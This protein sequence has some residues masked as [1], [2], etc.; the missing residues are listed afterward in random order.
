MLEFQFPFLVCV[1]EGLSK[2]KSLPRLAGDRNRIRFENT[3]R[4]DSC[5][6]LLFMLTSAYRFEPE[7]AMSTSL[8]VNL[9][10]ALLAM[11]HG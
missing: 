4:Q 11:S 8:I 5:F 9:S 1:E 3:L 2:S 10:C 6:V 7:V